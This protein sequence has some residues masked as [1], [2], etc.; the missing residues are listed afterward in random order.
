M[1]PLEK[2]IPKHVFKANA[3]EMNELTP[4]T[5]EIRA[6]ATCS[7]YAARAA[8]LRDEF[9]RPR[10]DYLKLSEILCEGYPRLRTYVYACLPYQAN[11]PTPE[12][13][14]LSAGKHQFFSALQKLLSFE[15]SFGKQGPRAG[16]FIQKGVDALLTVDLVRPSSKGPATALRACQMYSALM[17]WT[18][19]V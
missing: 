19:V 2:Q 1:F 17:T 9:E 10:V 3:S 7:S 14:Q 12:Q 16:G 18:G 8:I 6:K 11:P 15:T 4:Q 5:E 13:K